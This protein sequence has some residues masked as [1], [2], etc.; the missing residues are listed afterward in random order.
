MGNNVGELKFIWANC[1]GDAMTCHGNCDKVVCC[2]NSV[3]EG[4]DLF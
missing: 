1:T 4:K 2:T 3:L